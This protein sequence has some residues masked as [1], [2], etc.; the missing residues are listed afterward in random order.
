[1]Q[2]R[3]RD[4]RILSINMQPAEPRP[5]AFVQLHRGKGLIA[6]A[7]RWQTRGTYSHAAI[8][9]GANV[10]EAREFKGVRQLTIPVKGD[11]DEFSVPMTA[12]QMDQLE[13]F[14]VAQ[15]GKPYD[16]TMVLRFVTRRQE[17][18]RSTGKWFCSELCYAAFHHVG[19]EL[20]RNT[21]PWEVDPEFLSRSTLLI[22]TTI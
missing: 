19:I 16:Y 22:P 6:A 2:A 5:Q 12:E 17:T 18:R 10:Y 21:Q 3:F 15:L 7:I 4:P 20:F 13:R 14:C 1:M 9:V 11:Y 8:R